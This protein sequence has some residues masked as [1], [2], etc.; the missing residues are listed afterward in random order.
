[1]WH[2]VPVAGTGGVAGRARWLA[3]PV[4]HWLDHLPLN[5]RGDKFVSARKAAARSHV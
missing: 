1:M 3:K 5:A 2:H 4:Q